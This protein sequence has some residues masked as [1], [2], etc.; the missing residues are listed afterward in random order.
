MSEVKCENAAKRVTHSGLFGSTFFT[1]LRR[2]EERAPEHELY[3]R[4]DSSGEQQ[5]RREPGILV[6]QKNCPIHED[7]TGQ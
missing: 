2:E 7:S 6:E 1:E 4:K 5:S 3:T